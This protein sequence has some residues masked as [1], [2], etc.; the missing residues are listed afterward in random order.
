MRNASLVYT[1][2]LGLELTMGPMALSTYQVPT[3]KKKDQSGHFAFAGWAS[4][5]NGLKR[6][7]LVAIV[8]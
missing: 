2:R 5:T 8:S 4:G 3:A 7:T 1:E 6:Q